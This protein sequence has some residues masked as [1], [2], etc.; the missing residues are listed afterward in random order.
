MPDFGAVAAPHPAVGVVQT[1]RAYVALTK[2]N[3]IW[4]LLITTVPA[5]V[6]AE[7]AWPSTW[8]VAATLIGGS[9]AAGGA[10]AL[11]QYLERD[12]DARMERTSQRPL[13]QGSIAPRNAAIFG[14][15]LGVLNFS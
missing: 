12:I 7:R 6:V 3:I 4:L 5:M 14:L 13:P 1:L 9:L 11:N 10:N 8:L 2:P 15:L